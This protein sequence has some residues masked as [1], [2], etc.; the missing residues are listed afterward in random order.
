[1]FLWMD[2]FLL[3]WIPVVIHVGDVKLE[4]GSVGVLV[5][6]IPVILTP[7]VIAWTLL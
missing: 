5:G 7:A 2:E 4:V 3:V 6:S 1:M